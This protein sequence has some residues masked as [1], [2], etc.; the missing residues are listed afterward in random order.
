MNVR[1]TVILFTLILAIFGAA[2]VL[3]RILPTRMPLWLCLVIY[4]AV[5]FVLALAV[6]TLA[7][8]IG[9]VA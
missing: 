8:W 4:L 6:V 9:G 7:F 1:D 3:V 2:R 5:V